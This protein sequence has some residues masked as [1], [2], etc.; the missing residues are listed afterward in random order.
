[1]RKPAAG[2]GAHPGSATRGIPTVGLQHGFIYHSWLNYLHEED[3]MRPDPANPRM[4]D[5][6]ANQMLV[7]DDCAI[8]SR[9]VRAFSTRVAP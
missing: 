4:V 1:M 3:E 7:F 6:P 5:F 8:A 9:T 2:P